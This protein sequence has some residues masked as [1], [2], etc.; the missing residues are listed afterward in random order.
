MTAIPIL[1]GISAANDSGLNLSYPINLEP[2]PTKSGL[3]NGFMRTAPGA[4]PFATGPGLDRGGI[5][6]NG[7]LYRVMGTKLVKVAANG[8]VTEIGDVGSGGPVN[9]DYGFD[10]LAVNS[11]TKLYYSNGTSLNQ[12]TDTDLGAVYDVLWMDGYYVTTDGVNIVVT[13]LADPYAVNPLK[14]GSAEEDP[15]MVVALFKLRGELYVL[16]QYT[17]QVF[18]NVGGSGFPFQAN[19]A[20]TVPVG[21]VGP[22]ARTAFYQTLAFVGSGRGE[23]PAV[24]LLDGGTAAKISTRWIDDQIAAVADQTSITMET[25]MS[26]DERRLLVHLPDKTLIYCANASRISGQA[27]WYIAHSGLGLDRPYRMR[28]SVFCYGKW[29]CGD[30]QSA[31][32]GVLDDQVSTH[33]GDAAGWRFET[34]LLYNEGKGAILHDVELAGL[35][36]RA[37]LGVNPVAFMSTTVDGETWSMERACSTGKR[38]DLGRRVQWRLHRR[39]NNYMGLR[40]RGASEALAGWSTCQATVEGLNA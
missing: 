15:D 4:V 7:I 33:F 22:N 16:G 12:V 11:G 36:G 32:V 18:S 3:A 13:D 20:A 38:G 21:C 28:N 17:I 29:Y 14:Y 6:W 40:F 37:P 8:V 31:Q 9:M 24:Y 23:A 35:P 25:R 1:S 34:L 19:T 26:R 30:T 27:C 2:V 10:L 39:F 5:S